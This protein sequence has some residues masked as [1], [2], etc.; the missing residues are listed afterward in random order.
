MKHYDATASI[1]ESRYEKIQTAKIMAALRNLRTTKYGW[2]LD[3]GCG[4][5]ILLDHVAGN[6][7][8]VVGLDISRKTLIEAKKRAKNHVNVHLIW[9]DVEY[10]PIKSD[11]FE[12]VFAVTV[13]QN[14]PS[15]H[16]ALREINLA[17]KNDAVI[18]VT[19]LKKVFKKEFF[20]RLLEN[21]GL[22]V[23]ALENDGLECYVAVC[24]KAPS[25][26]SSC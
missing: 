23:V 22:D 24:S 15:P 20:Q 12:S 13:L 21:A 1:Y 17:A 16:N 2:V 25:G 9:A 4:T 5:G 26:A 3:A 14:T 6:T 19:G 18:A 10:M 8:A 11:V 7:T